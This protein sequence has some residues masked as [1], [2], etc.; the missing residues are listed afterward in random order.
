[1]PM[2][3][4]AVPMP[5]HAVP[6]TRGH[7]SG[8]RRPR[9]ANPVFHVATGR[10]PRREPRHSK[11]SASD[12]TLTVE[13][14][15]RYAFRLT[16]RPMQARDPRS[17]ICLVFPKPSLGDKRL[18]GSD[19]RSTQ[20]REGVGRSAGPQRVGRSG[21]VC[22]DDSRAISPNFL[23]RATIFEILMVLSPSHSRAE[24]KRAEPSPS[25]PR[26]VR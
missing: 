13:N 23:T 14:G 4:H 26:I 16:K 15:G 10:G 12:L 3:G 17:A 20:A 2:P 25:L 18:L 7:G 9:R 11:D 19:P 1:M 8:N 24:R 6:D 5:G 21:M 22:Q